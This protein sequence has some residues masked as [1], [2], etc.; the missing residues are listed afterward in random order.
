MGP[1]YR[2]VVQF[3][4]DREVSPSEVLG[5]KKRLVLRVLKNLETG[6]CHFEGSD[7]VLAVDKASGMKVPIRVDFTIPIATD[8]TG[9]DYQQAYDNWENALEEKRRAVQSQ[10][11]SAVLAAPPPPMHKG[12]KSP[13]EQPFG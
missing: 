1:I 5:G 4:H 7:M 13:F 9:S 6:D 11:D 2:S 8:E 3:A 10:L 12:E